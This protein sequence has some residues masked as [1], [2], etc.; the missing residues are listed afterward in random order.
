[1]R[2]FI[3]GLG[4]LSACTGS[5]GDMTGDDDLPPPA[6]DVQIRIQDGNTPIV[7]ASV[8]FQAADQSVI[9]E[10]LTDATGTALAEMPEGGNLTVIRTYPLATPPDEQQPIEVYTYVGVE[11]GDRLELGR[12]VDELALPGAINVMVPETAQGTINVKTPCGSGQGQPPLIPITVRGCDPSLIVYVT[13]GDQSSFVKQAPY[14]D[15]VDVSG[16]ALLGTLGSSLTATNV[17]LGTTVVSEKILEINGWEL[18]ASGEKRIDTESQTID[19][20]QLTNVDELQRTRITDTLN[21]SQIV[22][23]R[24]P[25]VRGTTVVD[26]SIGLIPYI[27]SPNYSP[28]GLSW[29]EQGPA[30][31][32]PNLVIATLTITRDLGGAPPGP[33]DIYV[34]AIVAPHAGST[35]PMPMLP[36]TAAMFNPGA[37][38]QIAGSLGLVQFSGEYVAAR[39]RVFAGASILDAAP[40]NGRVVL[41]Y[42]GNTPP[43]L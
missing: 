39:P 41:S 40:A 15:L 24:Q 21:R 11:P 9:A 33:N 27:A 12:K 16:E 32:Q 17:T 37:T 36:G 19:V 20:P 26:G 43:S 5:I 3:I 25:Y 29:V 10:L 42:T 13:D 31:A 8:I 4:L 14:G 35:L 30:Q 34:R 18:Y 2:H 22:A 28:T 7:G 38:D 23:Q 6:T 1:M